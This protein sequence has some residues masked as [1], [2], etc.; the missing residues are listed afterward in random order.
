MAATDLREQEMLRKKKLAAQSP[1][2]AGPAPMTIPQK[3]GAFASSF[4]SGAGYPGLAPVANEVGRRGAQAATGLVKGTYDNAG[5]GLLPAMAGGAIEAVRGAA[6]IPPKPAGPTPEQL[7]EQEALSNQ[8][9]APTKP[10][11]GPQ[12]DATG[13]E[14][15][16]SRT[17]AANARN[18]YRQAMRAGADRNALGAIMSD[19]HRAD[20]V[21]QGASYQKPET[22]ALSPARVAETRAKLQAQLDQQ[23]LAQGRGLSPQPEI[24]FQPY[25]YEAAQEGVKRGVDRY[26]SVQAQAQKSL[27]DIRE[28]EML[29]A[30]SARLPAQ[31][32]VEQGGASLAQA[33]D[34]RQLAE[35]SAKVAPQR[36]QQNVEAERI[37]NMAG[38]KK[39]SR[40]AAS[41][42]GGIT[43]DQVLK[44]GE[45]IFN[46]V[47][48][49]TTGLADGVLTE[50]LLGGDIAKEHQSLRTF[51]NSLGRLAEY[52]K[53]DPAGAADAA[54]LMLGSLPP[55]T[56]DGTYKYAGPL[57][58]KSGGDYVQTLNDIRKQI[59]A[60]ASG[61][62]Q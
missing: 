14:A 61:S 47:K 3:I 1:V 27:T 24:Q 45:G 51:Q 12:V 53:Y 8:P 33:N 29:R 56:A 28:G 57:T 43:P 13:R 36:V 15:A 55:T 58:F 21:A 48:T 54:N 5:R 32:A 50:R 37:K 19:I 35:A 39:A 41:T 9:M 52:A 7:R 4:A 40:D 42:I 16:R 22:E 34:R 6:D 31:I 44:D 25:D 38:A 17:Y 30:K 60:L 62:V 46:M 10:T 18:D 2:E 11:P 49:R 59:E 23:K 20:D 26:N